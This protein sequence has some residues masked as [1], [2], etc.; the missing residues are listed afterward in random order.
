MV[1]A[2][3]MEDMK[4]AE[5]TPRTGLTVDMAAALVTAP[6]CTFPDDM[7]NREHPGLCWSL[8]TGCEHCSAVAS[9]MTTHESK[10]QRAAAAAQARL[11]LR[12]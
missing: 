7:S 4:N 5:P 9:A 3:E 12:A 11:A 6:Q 2:V 1:N 10:R 8:T